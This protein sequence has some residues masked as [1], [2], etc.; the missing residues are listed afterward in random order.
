MFL[1]D[2]VIMVA[3]NFQK[4]GSIDQQ[5]LLNLAIESFDW[6][7]LIFRITTKHRNQHTSLQGIHSIH[8]F[9]NK[10]IYVRF[11]AWLFDEEK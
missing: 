6:V 11:D 5:E 9:L 7:C 8:G 3:T 1:F 4:D 10:V 2:D